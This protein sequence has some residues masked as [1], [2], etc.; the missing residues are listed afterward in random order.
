[1]MVHFFE[2]FATEPIFGCGEYAFVRDVHG[3]AFLGVELRASR[4]CCN[5][6]RSTG[7]EMF[8]YIMQSSA[9]GEW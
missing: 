4:S 9:K 6:F 8:S 7:E 2:L 3:E 1:M 5:V